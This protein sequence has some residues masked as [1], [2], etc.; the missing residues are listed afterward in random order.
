MLFHVYID[1]AIL[2]LDAFFQMDRIVSDLSDGFADLC[3]AIEV[4]I[5]EL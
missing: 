2:T 4:T 1:I 3:G 5:A